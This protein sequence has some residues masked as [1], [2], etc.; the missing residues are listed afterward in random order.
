MNWRTLGLIRNLKRTGAQPVMNFFHSGDLG[1]VLYALPAM[2]SMGGGSLYLNS[3]PWTAA[4]TEERV[5]VIKPLLEIQDYV[6]SVTHGDASGKV[7]DFSTFRKGG[8]PYGVS[9]VELQADWVG[10]TPDFKPWLAVD[11]PDLRADGRVICHR[12]SRYNNPYFPW[13]EIGKKFGD[14]LLLVGFREEANNLRDELGF[15]AEYL[16]TKNYLELARLISCA[17][18]FIG[19]QSSPMALALGLGAPVLQETCLWVCD[20]LFPRLNAEYCYD[21]GIKSLGVEPHRLPP[22]ID[23]SGL[24]QGGWIVRNRLGETFRGQSHKSAVSF[25]LYSNDFD[26]T[27]EG[28]AKAEQEVD[29]QQAK[30]IPGL[31]LRDSREQV[32]GLVERAVSSVLEGMLS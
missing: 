6:E 27:T 7:V 16:P 21:G 23:R 15:D 2:R 10:E 8:L 22:D 19:N 5:R 4:M 30:R 29:Y 12:S 24:P 20:C 26:R 18:L 13:A 9:L 31:V 1:D 14:R 11:K 17:D 3:R 28:V 25:L 32:F